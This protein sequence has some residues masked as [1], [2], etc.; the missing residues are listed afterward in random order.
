MTSSSSLK[1][2]KNSTPRCHVPER[3]PR[4][5]FN[6]RHRPCTVPPYHDPRTFSGRRFLT[7]SG[8][9]TLS[10]PHTARAAPPQFNH[11][12]TAWFI[13]NGLLRRTANAS[14]CRC[15]AGVT[16]SLQSV[17]LV[18]CNPSAGKS[19]RWSVH[20]RLHLLVQINQLASSNT[21]DFSFFYALI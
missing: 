7:A 5:L 18:L 15:K 11:R 2:S 14:E 8:W 17:R 16:R 9:T 12:Y 10:A 20:T 4:T 3:C 13:E 19:H 1:E 6:F 21:L